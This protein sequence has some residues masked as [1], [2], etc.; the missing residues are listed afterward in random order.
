M[1]IHIISYLIFSDNLK[2]LTENAEK[3]L[4]EFCNIYADIFISVSQD[5]AL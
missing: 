2:E 5:L 4:F 1:H 3:I